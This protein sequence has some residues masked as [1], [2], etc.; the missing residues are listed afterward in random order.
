[1]EVIDLVRYFGALVLVLALVGVVGLALRRF[2]SGFAGAKGRRLKLLE[3]LMMGARHRLVLVRCD[4]VEHVIVL[5]PQGATLVD[6]A[7]TVASQSE[8]VPQT[9][10]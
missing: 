9:P 3:S 6:S 7:M 8:P 2:G 10:A 1:M 5:G 4:E